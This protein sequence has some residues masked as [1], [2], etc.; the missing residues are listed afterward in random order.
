MINP[1]GNH[2]WESGDFAWYKT[3]IDHAPGFQHLLVKVV[4]DRY[5]IGNLA[6]RFSRS[7]FKKKFL[8]PSMYKSDWPL[9]T[10]CRPISDIEQLALT[11]DPKF[12]DDYEFFHSP[13]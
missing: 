2:Q 7:E 5:R 13:I 8:T 10:H 9:L 1:R 12:K 11:T 4:P 3:P 6:I